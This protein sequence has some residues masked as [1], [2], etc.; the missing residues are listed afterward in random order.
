M[1]QVL[2]HNDP[3]DI[4]GY[5]IEARLGSG[6][7]GQVYLA[8]TEPGRRVA[9]KV[10]K[11]ALAKNPEFRTRFAREVDAA[12]MVSGVHTASVLD[13]DAAADPPWLVCEYIPGPS[14]GQ[15][16][17]E[18]GPLRLGQLRALGRGLARGLAEIHR[19][20]LVHR[21]L[22]PAN[23]IMAEEGPRIID[24]GIARAVDASTLTAVGTVIGTYA[25][26][27][28]E[29]VVADTATPAS[30]VFALG[31][32]LAFAATGEGPF[33]ATGIPAIVHRITSEAPR[34][35]GV[36]D[37]LR[38]L[39]AACLAK[40]P[41]HRPGLD[42]VVTELTADPALSEA[43]TVPP[44]ERDLGHAVA[45]AAVPATEVPETEIVHVAEAVPPSRGLLSRRSVLFG[46]L[47]VA[48]V[49]ATA[50]TAA[51]LWPKIAGVGDPGAD[52]VIATDGGE[53]LIHGFAFA[54]DGGTIATTGSAG[55]RLW[56]VRT[57]KTV[58]EFRGGN[59]YCVTFSEDGTR[60]GAG[61][62]PVRVWDARD[63][64]EIAELEVNN[65]ALELY[66]S[67]NGKAVITGPGSEGD[68]IGDGKGVEL[69]DVDRGERIGELNRDAAQG[70]EF[71]PDSE[72][73]VTSSNSGTFLWSAA[74]GKKVRT[75]S[76][77]FGGRAV[78]TPDGRNLITD[79]MSGVVMWDVASGDKVRVISRSGGA[80]LV[81]PDG[82]IL[83]SDDG[84]RIVHLW[85]L[86]SGDKIRTLELDGQF[87][88]DAFKNMAFSPDSRTLVTGISDVRLWPVKGTGKPRTLTTG[89]LPVHQVG[90][91]RDG[92]TV[93]ALAGDGSNGDEYS[94]NLWHV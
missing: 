58:R 65:E 90:Y 14:L 57:G 46:G 40:N 74:T 21:D 23:V 53:D 75:I 22:K 52:V 83:A 3:R 18:R 26:M 71:S 19:C 27:S 1:T 67:P 37:S 87:V 31:C 91:S 47:A 20:G 36:P 51:L 32:L 84:V 60:L 81:S 80:G 70:M 41:L 63:G 77:E 48:G 78:F 45:R 34:L 39:V 62:Y 94:V 17:A 29:Q 56:D 38:H 5:R 59:A 13:A 42:D 85:D 88:M 72:L 30:D 15:V 49:G 55:I 35:E 8:V 79:S 11:P 33:D 24:F 2:R 92:K 69:F 89:Y 66:F 9:V 64:D 25:Y 12:R 28:P 44:D 82:K 61:T 73:V 7:M 43:D 68:G 16:V 10:L 86:T 4:G 76:K 93:A 6:G 54:P 50:A